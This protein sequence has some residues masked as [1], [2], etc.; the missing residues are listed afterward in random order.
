M[1]G[2]ALPATPL[3]LQEFLGDNANIQ[4][5]IK[6]GTFADV[7]KNYASAMQKRDESIATQV[8]EQVE[9]G[10]TE[11]LKENAQNAKVS[12]AGRTDNSLKNNKIYNKKAAGAALDG[13]FEDTAD[14]LRTIHHNSDRLNHSNQ[15]EPKA[16]LDKVRKVQNSFGSQIPADGGFLVPET[17]R[18]QLLQWSLENSVVRPRAT[19]IPMETLRVPI[20]IVDSTSNVSSVF[21]GIVAYWTEESAALTESQATFGRIV[22]E[23][24]KLTA[25]CT[26]P[27]ELLADASAFGAFIDQKLPQAISFYE[28]YAF[29]QGS[30]VG[31]PMGLLNN[32]ATVTVA[33]VAGQGANTIL[34]ENVVAM[35]AR[36]LPSSLSNAVWLVSPDVFPQLATMA[37]SVGTGGTAIWL[38]NGQ[39]A[40]TLTLLG[41]P[42]IVTEKVPALGTTGDI[43]FADLSYYLVGD[44]QALQVASS[45]HFRFQ[46]DQTAYRVIERVDG[47]P[48]LQSAI[49]PKNN[50]ATL[51]PF[52]QL[53]STRT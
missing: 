35:Y 18:S 44:R 40:P 31:E 27:N 10:L 33:A 8:H 21:G 47:R 26:V 38:Q 7:V 50:S 12:H 4:N 11:F 22:L 6:D 5:S 1:T 19:V 24:K 43:I 16:R 13:D 39:A 46:N 36:M 53:S 28:D 30:G 49:T 25:Y 51:S 52:V 3:E 15:D 34:W 17:L 32:P 37:L 41:R 14:F 9:A 23:A 42:V 45:E 2:K 48:W 20:P 29:I